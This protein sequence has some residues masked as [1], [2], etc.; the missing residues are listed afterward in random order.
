MSCEKTVASLGQ[1]FPVKQRSLLFFLRKVPCLWLARS[2]RDTDAQGSEFHITFGDNKL[3]QFP[4]PRSGNESE[5]WDS[6]ISSIYKYDL[7]LLWISRN[8]YYKITVPFGGDSSPGPSLKNS[9][10]IATFLFR[11]TCWDNAAVFTILRRV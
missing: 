4:V 9:E 1:Y 3:N 2:Q 8:P 10:F 11:A 5:D 7:M 6:P